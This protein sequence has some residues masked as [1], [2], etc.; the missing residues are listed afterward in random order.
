MAL[1][2]HSRRRT[3]PPVPRPGL[4]TPAPTAGANKH[5]I[6]WTVFVALVVAICIVKVLSLTNLITEPVFAA[7]SIAVT[8]FILARF[9]FARVYLRALKRRN[10]TEDLVQVTYQPTVAIIVPAYNEPDIARTMKACLAADYPHDKL[11]VVVV[12]DKSTDDTLAIIRR[13]ESELDDERLLVIAPPVNQGKRHAIGTGLA[14]LRADEGE[15][16]VFIDSDSQIEPDAISALIRHFADPEVGAVAGHTDVANKSVNILTRMQAMQYFIAFRVHKSAESLFDAVGCCSGCFSGYR[17][18]ALEP[19]LDDWLGQTF[20]GTPSTYGDDRSL[21]NFLLR[22]WKV[23][24]APDAQAYTNVPERMKQLL[25]QQ[26]RWKKSWMRESL[27]AA[28]AMWHKHPVMIAMFFVGVILPLAAPQIVF[29]AFVVQPYF[30]HE[31]PIWYL[32]GV[33]TI[34]LL[35]G[36]YYRAHQREPRWYLGMFFTLF[37]TIV[38]VVQLPYAMLTIRDSKWGTR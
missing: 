13:T 34:A 15:I 31:F 4:P 37:Y 8:T 36:L 17:R 33:A 19:I 23:V 25:K 22:N 1:L 26:L 20:F 12:D 29:R 38:L 32:G 9:G 11:R 24:Y 10:D 28:R 14:A 18:T 7:Y 21:T 3:A 35:Y 2:T 16:C 6:L 5:R 30:L 27:R